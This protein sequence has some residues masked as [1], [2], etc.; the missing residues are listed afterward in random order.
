LNQNQNFGGFG[1]LLPQLHPGV[2]PFD[3]L[4]FASS[5]PCLTLA[6]IGATAMHSRTIDRIHFSLNMS[7]ILTKYYTEYKKGNTWTKVKLF[8]VKT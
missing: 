4:S 5:L 3:I 1:G 7:D 6:F 8:S 2:C